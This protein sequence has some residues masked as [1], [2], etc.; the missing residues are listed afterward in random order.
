MGT[1]DC[2]TCAQPFNF[3]DLCAVSDGLFCYDCL[4]LFQQSK[5]DAWTVN[6]KNHLA[7]IESIVSEMSDLNIYTMKVKVD[8]YVAKLSKELTELIS[9]AK[10]G[11]IAAPQVNL[12][13][14]T[15]V[16]PAIELPSPIIVSA[17]TS[18]SSPVIPTLYGGSLQWSVT[19]GPI[20]DTLAINCVDLNGLETVEFG[21]NFTFRNTPVSFATSGLP[22]YALSNVS[23]TGFA[24]RGAVTTGILY[25]M[26]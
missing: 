15:P 6:S 22:T 13:P 23:K 2:Q 11:V 26:G 17:P 10:T 14:T 8:E 16:I 3:T 7:N 21:D 18:Y 20:F 9:L 12:A 1:Q 4:K 24:I 5:S 25:L 19:Y